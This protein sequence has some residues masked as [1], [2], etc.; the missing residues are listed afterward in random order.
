MKSKFFLLMM[1][2]LCQ[3]CVTIG[4]VGSSVVSD[5]EILHQEYLRKLYSGYQIQLTGES[6]VYATISGFPYQ[7]FQSLKTGGFVPFRVD[8]IF[9]K[10]LMNLREM[11]THPVD[12][13]NRPPYGYYTPNQ[14]LLP[15]RI[16]PGVYDIEVWGG[17]RSPTAT[18]IPNVIVEAG[19][20][21]VI[22]PQRFQEA[23][24][25]SIREYQSDF[26]FNPNEEGFYVLKKS[27]S[28]EVFYGNK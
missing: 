19:K 23:W 22:Y 21:Y 12:W 28:P 20:Q 4:V 3:G 7:G 16:K 18:R 11:L 6:E 25:I 26:T 17:A 9:I 15:L 24:R 10:N 1:L 27:V 14:S 2:V 8:G 13:I 5:S